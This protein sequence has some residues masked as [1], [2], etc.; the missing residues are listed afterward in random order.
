M[1]GHLVDR[2]RL[3]YIFQYSWC[4]R[5]YSGVCYVFHDHIV[6][7]HSQKKMLK[8]YG[9]STCTDILAFSTMTWGG[10]FLWYW[11]SL[12]FVC[13]FSSL[14][15]RRLTD[16]VDF[17]PQIKCH[18]NLNNEVIYRVEIKLLLLS[19]SVGSIIYADLYGSIKIKFTVL[20]PMRINKDLCGS[21]QDQF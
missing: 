20:I 21:M 13:G 6:A 1:S 4:N 14:N 16:E 19:G 5:E 18:Q 3:H 2:T 8:W 9:L 17:P 10:V 12:S 11:L 7:L 15:N